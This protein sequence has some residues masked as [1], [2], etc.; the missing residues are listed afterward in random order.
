MSGTKL[1]DTV[2]VAA[3]SLRHAGLDAVRELAWRTYFSVRSSTDA[4]PILSADWDLLVVLDAC[5][6]DLFSDVLSETNRAYEGIHAGTTRTSPA[7][8][9]EEWLRNVFVDA[10]SNE[11]ADVAYVSGNPYTARVLDADRFGTVVDVW[12][13]AWDDDLGTIPPRPITDRAIELGREDRFDR[14]VVHYMQPHFP[15]LAAPDSEDRGVALSQFGDESMSVWE[16]LR[17]GR[18]SESTVWERY[19]ANLEAVLEEVECLLAN[20]DAESAVITADHGN[21][22]GEYGI[23]GHPGGVDLPC[24]REVPWCETTATDRRTREPDADESAGAEGDTPAEEQ[25]ATVEERLEQ[26]GYRS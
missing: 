23:Y 4:D 3:R 17:F 13:E 1:T 16:D 25:R 9:S 6:A 10:D 24:L 15:S 2:T 7:S 8:S 14:L 19:R 12:R 21:A 11:L 18:V 26:L 22:I 20:V 5:R